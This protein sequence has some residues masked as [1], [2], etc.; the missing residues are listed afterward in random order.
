[1]RDPLHNCCHPSRHDPRRASRGSTRIRGN[2]RAECLEEIQG[3]GRLLDAEKIRELAEQGDIRAQTLLGLMYEQGDHLVEKNSAIAEM[4]YRKAAEQGD[5]DGQNSLGR[6]YAKSEYSWD[7]PK[8][9]KWYRKA[10]EQGEPAAQHNLA[11]MYYD[12][13]GVPE[14]YQ[15]SVKWYRK[16]AEQGDPGAQSKLGFMYARGEGVKKDH[17][18][19]YAWANLAA[20]RGEEMIVTPLTFGFE[21]KETTLKDWLRGQMSSQQ[22]SKAQKL[23]REIHK[24]IESIL[25][26]SEALASRPR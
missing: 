5:A 20:A 17:V 24:H 9:V 1:M 7:W 4:W 16:A 23:S 21:G 26:I 2:R 15:E 25:K 19:A 8:A 14:D 12:G 18:K 10:A 6:M 22:V 3:G 13:R 11:T